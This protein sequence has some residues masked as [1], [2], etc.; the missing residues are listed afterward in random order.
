[1]T[2]PRH[3][4]A[5]R[6]PVL[7]RW[8]AH[9]ATPTPV[10]SPVTLPAAAVPPRAGSAV[11]P[12]VGLDGDPS[13]WFD[14]PDPDNQCHAVQPDDGTLLASVLR[15]VGARSSARL[16]DA[17][18][19]RSRCLTTAHRECSRFLAAMQVLAAPGAAT[20]LPSTIATATPPRVEVSGPQATSNGRR[21]EAT[22]SGDPDERITPSDRAAPTKR[23]TAAAASSGLER[24]GAPRSDRAR[25]SA[26]AAD[27]EAANVQQ[28]SETDGSPPQVGAPA[29]EPK[30]QG[31]QSTSARTPRTTTRSATPAT[32][33]VVEAPSS[34]GGSD[35]SG[36]ATT[37]TNDGRKSTA[38][39]TDGPKSD[40][41]GD[42]T[43]TDGPKSTATKTD[44]TKTDGPKSDATGDATKTDGPKSDATGDAEAEMPPKRRKRARSSTPGTTK[45]ASSNGSAPKG[46]KSASTGSRASRSSRS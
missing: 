37:R 36:N 25:S 29:P 34:T 9:G 13:T 11:C 17:E 15:R 28:M 6:S 21:P 27:V 35:G 24:K 14:F 31:P 4:S 7:L 38:T 20:T 23:V 45:R 22:P 19:Q 44:A 2:P 3:R 5:R 43:K 10:A 40:A 41:T 46:R 33:K 32:R 39:K 1:M 42:A 18:T 26:V 16:L 30:N 12:F 8:R